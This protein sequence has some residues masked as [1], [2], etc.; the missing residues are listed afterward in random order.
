MFTRPSVAIAAILAVAFVVVALI[1]GIV[2]LAWNDKSTE[3]L[4]LVIAGPLI[5]ALVA[6]MGRLRSIESKVDA[7]TTTTLDGG[8]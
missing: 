4:T 2:L 8:K 6:V 3:A 1:V 7:A 5:G